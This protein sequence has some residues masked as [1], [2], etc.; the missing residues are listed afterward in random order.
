MTATIPHFWGRCAGI[1][2][3][4][5]KLRGMFRVS[6]PELKND[7]SIATTRRALI[8]DDECGIRSLLA[9]WLAGEGFECLQAESAHRARELLHGAAIDLVTLDINMPGTTGTELLDEIIAI[10]PERRGAD[11]HGHAGGPHRDRRPAAGRRGLPGQAGLARTV[12]DASAAVACP[13]RHAHPT[14]AVHAVAGTAEPPADPG[15]PPRPR[16]NHPP[17]CGRQ[18]SAATWRPGPTLFAPA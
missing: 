2:L 18:Q 3:C 7:S 1:I 4:F 9:R 11:G 8:V 6:A 10:C 17:P 14:A 12:A 16:G 15:H 5:R 13:A